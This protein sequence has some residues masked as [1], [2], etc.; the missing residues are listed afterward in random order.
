LVGNPQTGVP[1][2]SELY[3]L[4]GKDT[5]KVESPVRDFGKLRTNTALKLP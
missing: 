1:N 5:P 4:L 3:K 2:L